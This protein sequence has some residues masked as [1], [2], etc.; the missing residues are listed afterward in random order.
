M[1]KPLVFKYRDGEIAFAMSKVDR[2][3][4]YGFK[5][6]EVLDDDGHKCELATLAG[7]GRTV[8]GKGGTA[9]AYV[10][11]E[12]N[13]CERS[14]LKPV[15]LEGNE[16]EPVPS[17]FSEAVALDDK[18]SIEDYL[19]HN[20]RSVYQMDSEDDTSALMD[21]LKAGA[22]YKFAYSFRGG[23]EADAAFLLTNGD[24]ELFMAVGNPT[25]VE[26]IG[27]QQTAGVAAEDEAAE[28]EG[29]LMDFGMI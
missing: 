24:G 10:S 21:E 12:G 5:E 14:Q 3:K 8:I 18:V 29:D 25:T 15:N 27:L 2:A 17:S 1:A 7:D 11:S 9:M 28:E 16:I 6:V 22:I 4:L 19:E 23:L 26:F 20:I 13:W